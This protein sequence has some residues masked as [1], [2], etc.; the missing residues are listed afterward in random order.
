LT[1][2]W[3][4]LVGLLFPGCASENFGEEFFGEVGR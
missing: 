4:C 2:A 3:T 1:A